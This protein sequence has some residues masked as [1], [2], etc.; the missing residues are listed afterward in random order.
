MKPTY[1]IND[2]DKHFENHESRK[3]KRSYW[4]PIPNK[5]DG[6][7]YRRIASHPDGVAVFAAWILILEAA[8]KMPTRGVLAD[9]DG[10]LD[11]DDLSAMTGFPAAIFEAAFRLLPEDRV[12]W[13]VVEEAKPRRRKSP[14]T[15]RNL[16]ESPGAPGN[17][18]VELHGTELQDTE[19]KNREQNEEEDSAKAGASAAAS[20]QGAEFTIWRLGTGKL[21]SASGMDEQA[22]R[23]LLGGLCKTHGKEKVAEVI[24]KMLAQEPADPK[25]Y[26]VAILQNGNSNGSNKQNSKQHVVPRGDFEFKPKSVIR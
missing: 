9:E 6:K 10:P 16:P 15:S 22:A 24:T 20:P 3:V 14:A 26:L 4:V 25:T 18:A 13:L 21:M 11:A 12:G 8:S 2:W 7:S 23:S 19:P 1:R 5:H 17:A